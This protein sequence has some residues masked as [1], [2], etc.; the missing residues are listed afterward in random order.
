VAVWGVLIGKNVGYFLEDR[1]LSEAFLPEILKLPFFKKE[2]VQVVI[3]K[4]NLTFI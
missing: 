4:N 3:D 1:R 2:R